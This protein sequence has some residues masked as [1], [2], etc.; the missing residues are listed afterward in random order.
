MVCKISTTFISMS[1]TNKI[2]F[3]M[4]SHDKVIMN[5]IASYVFHYFKLSII[6]MFSANLSAMM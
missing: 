5:G 4:T 3:L 6:W 1:N 2:I